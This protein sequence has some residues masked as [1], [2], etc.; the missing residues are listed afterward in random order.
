M[1]VCRSRCRHMAEFIK[2]THTSAKGEFRKTRINSGENG[3]PIIRNV[4]TTHIHKKMI[5]FILC[6]LFLYY[7]VLRNT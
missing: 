4:S 3:P 2:N 1:D 7:T 6:L 5:F